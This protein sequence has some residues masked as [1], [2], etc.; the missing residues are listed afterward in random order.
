MKGQMRAARL[1]KK[2]DLRI[3][4][5]PVPP[6]GPDEVLVR[7]K[8]VGVCG[9][10]VHFFKNGRIGRTVVTEPIILGHEPAGEVAEV[11][12]QVDH[13]KPGDRVAIEPQRPCRRC[14]FCRAGRYNLCENIMFCGTPPTD[15]PFAEYYASPAW[16]CH[17]VP[18]SFSDETA[19]LM[20]PAAIGL[21]AAD[22]SPVK[23][24]DMIAVFGCGNIGLMTMQFA[25]L[26]GAEHIIAVDKLDYRLD[27]AGLLG[28]DIAVN[29]DRTD[30]VQAVMEAT[31]GRGV[32]VAFEAAGVPETFQWSLECARRGGTAMLIGI[33]AEDYVPLE[34]HGP[35]RKELTIQLVRRFN[36]THPRAIQLVREGRIQTEPLVTQRFGLDEI[37]RALDIVENYKNN[38][39]RAFITFD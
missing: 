10:D 17:R 18:E 31:A 24:G 20:E 32:D 29:P 12:G 37:V 28:A 1:H 35:R 38:V 22:L 26:M 34:M 30:C 36:L 11:G 13:L 7:I 16:I 27:V 14:E 23:P 21:H 9:S 8:A 15:G 4:R 25:K 33:C 5:V 19:A 39:I 6:V 3:E 2:R